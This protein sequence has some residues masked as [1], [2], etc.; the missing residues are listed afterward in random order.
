M[1]DDI[2]DHTKVIDA[3]NFS[4][5]TQ[6]TINSVLN[7]MNKHEASIICLLY[8][9]KLE[10]GIIEGTKGIRLINQYQRE[11]SM[12]PINNFFKTG[13]L[14]ISDDGKNYI[15]LRLTMEKG[16]N[17]DETIYGNLTKFASWDHEW[18]SW[19]NRN[20]EHYPD[21][22]LK[23]PFYHTEEKN[24]QLFKGFISF[25]EKKDNRS[26][27]E[28]EYEDIDNDYDFGSEVEDN[29]SAQMGRSG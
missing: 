7:L 25:I 1:T 12:F 28:N 19:A 4:Y 21:G 17:D 3:T 8:R 16:L 11:F 6:T 20:I 14:K 5:E 9:I 26:Y 18:Y 15:M 27:N 29:W 23:I 10:Y 13:I 22:R 24:D 2:R